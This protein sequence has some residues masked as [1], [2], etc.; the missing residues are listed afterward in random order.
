M[1]ISK[2]MHDKQY[3]MQ[4]TAGPE[5]KTASTKKDQRRMHTGFRFTATGNTASPLYTIYI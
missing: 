2:T 3:L 5:V 1:E 4:M